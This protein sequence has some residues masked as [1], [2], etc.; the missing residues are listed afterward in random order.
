MTDDY[1]RCQITCSSVMPYDTHAKDTRNP[2]GKCLKA[3]VGGQRTK[4]KF[5]ISLLNVPLLGK[6]FLP[7][8]KKKKPKHPKRS[9]EICH[10]LQTSAMIQECKSNQKINTDV[11][12]LSVGYHCTL[13]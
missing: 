11:L 1:L 12:T 6:S 13:L 3:H 8:K 5:C 10:R 7:L 9:L 2:G 4:F